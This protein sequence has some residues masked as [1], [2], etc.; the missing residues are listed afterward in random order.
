[1]KN[2]YIKL[3]LLALS[4]FFA[5]SLH[6]YN[7][8]VSGIY[9]SITSSTDKTVSVTYKS[10]SHYSYYSDYS[11]TIVIPNEVTYNSITYNVTSIN[12]H[13]FDGCTGLTSVTIPSSVTSIS[14][15]AFKGCTGLTSVTIPSS[16]TT[17]GYNA[18]EGCTSLQN[19]AIL[20]NPIIEHAAF[21]NTPYFDNMPD[22]MVYINNVAYKYKGTMPADTSIK[23]KEGTTHI[24]GAFRDCTGLL[25]VSIPS[26][27]T[28]IGY[29]AFKGCTGLTSVT[30]PSGV[31]SIGSA[32][33]NG[34]TG[35]TSVTIPSS[36]T[37]INDYAFQTCN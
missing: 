9:Y 17:I 13:A 28:S 19:V 31:T 6:A 22:G 26:S 5:Q 1:M 15:Y 23:I 24:A 29:E 3:C 4:A 10:Y 18:F 11:G 16:V 25:S 2:L 20:G 7:F 8:K 35:L 14:S 37:S 27:V 33:F 12:E 21:D 32:A 30:I 36:V 34:C